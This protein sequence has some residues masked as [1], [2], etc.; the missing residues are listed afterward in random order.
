MTKNSTHVIYMQHPVHHV[1]SVA[2]RVGYYYEGIKVIGYELQFPDGHRCKLR[3]AEIRALK[4]AYVGA[5][6]EGVTVA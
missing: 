5:G 2:E 4:A 3:Y 6:G 1:P